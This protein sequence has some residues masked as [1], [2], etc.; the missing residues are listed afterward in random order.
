MPEDGRAVYEVG[1]REESCIAATYLL[2]PSLFPAAYRRIPPT[3]CCGTSDAVSEATI[4]PS[5]HRFFFLILHSSRFASSVPLS[6]LM[7]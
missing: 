6:H 5:S 4:V 7:G 3:L 2:L 1:E